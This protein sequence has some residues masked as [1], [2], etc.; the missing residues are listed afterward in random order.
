[1]F[2]SMLEVVVKFIGVM[3][4]QD[5]LLSILLNYVMVSLVKVICDI[6]VG[7]LQVGWYVGKLVVQKIVLVSMVVQFDLYWVMIYNKGI[8]NGIDVVVIVS[9]NDWCVLES[10]VYVYVVKDG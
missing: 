5:V 2:N 4:K 6:L 8:M 7:L 3:M 9:G 1:M 10:G